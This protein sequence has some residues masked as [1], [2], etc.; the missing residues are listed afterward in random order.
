MP[1]ELIQLCL[2]MYFINIGVWNVAINPD[3]EYIF[4]NEDRTARVADSNMEIKSMQR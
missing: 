2:L 4:E 1:D 3:N